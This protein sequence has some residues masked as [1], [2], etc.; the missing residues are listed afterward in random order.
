MQSKIVVLFLLVSVLCV[1]SCEKL[2]VGVE[3]PNQVG[4]LQFSKTQFDDS[5][6][7]SL[8]RFVAVTPHPTDGHWAA[9]WFEQDNG[10]ISVVWVNVVKRRIQDHVLTIPRK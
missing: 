8:G 10:T 6:A 2:D 3:N 1:I 4:A 7:Q 9:L 5:I